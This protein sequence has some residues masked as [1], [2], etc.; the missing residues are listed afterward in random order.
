MIL[1]TGG[2][3]FIGRNLVQGLVESGY[4]VRILLRPSKKSPRLPRGIPVE[5]AVSS[6]SDERGLRASLKGVDTIFHLASA[7]RQG[8]RGDLNSVDILGTAAIARSAKDAGISRLIFVSHLGADPMSAFPVLK[9]KGIAE[10]WIINSEVPYTILQTDAIFGPG[11]QF[12]IPIYQLIKQAP[13]FAMPGDGSTLLQ[14][15]AIGDIVSCLL[16]LLE[17]DRMINRRMAIG[18][19][20]MIS[21]REIVQIV[22]DTTRKKKP[23]IQITPAYLRVVGL[24]LDQLF[25]RFHMSIYWLDTLAINRTPNLDVLPKEFGVIPARFRNHLNYLAEMAQSR[26]R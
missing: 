6:L 19:S 10:N 12:T 7:E 1:V 17:D 11:D 21:Y 25:P 23:I 26:K 2:T 15:L 20:E 8:A 4:Q 14:P 9:A 3:G 22:M 16:M 18:G 24:W 13:F 5:V